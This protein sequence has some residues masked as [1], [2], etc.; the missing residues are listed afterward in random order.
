MKEVDRMTRL[1]GQPVELFRFNYAANC[2]EFKTEGNLYWVMVPEDFDYSDE[3]LVEKFVNLI[4]GCQA[5]RVE[6]GRREDS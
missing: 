5:R 1:L 4:K 6:A 3:E 2:F